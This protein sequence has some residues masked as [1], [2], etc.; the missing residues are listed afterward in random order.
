[1]AFKGEIR[2]LRR[3]LAGLWNRQ[4]LVFLFFLVL[5][6]IFW[7]SQALGD[8]YEQE[9]EVKV[10]LRSVPRGVVIT[11]DVPSTIRVTLK[12]RGINLL[13]YKYNDQLPAIVIDSTR[14]AKNRNSFYLLAAELAQQIRPALAQ[15]TQI[16]G[17]KPD[18]LAVEYNNGRSKRIPLRLASGS[19]TAAAGY[20]VSSE[21]L[22][23]D[24][25]TIFAPRAVLDTIRA[26]YVAPEG[27][28]TLT[29]SKN[30]EVQLPR[31]RGVK[32]Q[33]ASV[34]LSLR[35]EQ[36]VEKRLTVPV[37]SEN[38]PAGINVYT[39]P[40][41]VEVVCQV[42]MS[43]Y[44]GIN[45][46]HFRLIVDYNA[47]PQDGSKKCSLVL[48]SYPRSAKNIRLSQQEVE[49]VVDK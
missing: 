14:F 8:V 39:F 41:Q 36:L 47:L 9:F 16:V 24:S 18:T 22:S 25:V 21:R 6:A 46:S 48:K 20:V 19:V 27:A 37:E 7:L 26:V 42:P 45:A 4:A 44:R 30:L 23:T 10:E 38:C 35:V 17:I 29:T 3:V 11:S 1:M 12:D 2:R 5:S 49:Y 34:K 15:G 33:P 32:Y 31:P 28:R 43:A 13:G 40:A